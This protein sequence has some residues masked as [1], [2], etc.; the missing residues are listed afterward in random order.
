MNPDLSVIP[1]DFLV[2]PDEVINGLYLELSINKAR[3]P[4]TLLGFREIDNIFVA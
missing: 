1:K 2:V 3:V 4:C